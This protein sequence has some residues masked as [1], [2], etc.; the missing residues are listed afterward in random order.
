MTFRK[1]FIHKFCVTNE[2]ELGAACLHKVIYFGFVRFLSET[3]SIRNFSIAV[4]SQ[5][6]FEIFVLFRPFTVSRLK[7]SLAVQ[8]KFDLLAD[9]VA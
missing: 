2:P 3:H 5:P 1:N 8:M 6:L 9:L 4:Q 7:S